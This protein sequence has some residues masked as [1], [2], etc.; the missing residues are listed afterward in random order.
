METAKQEVHLRVVDEYRQ[1]DSHV[2]L[3]NIQFEV[4]RDKRDGAFYNIHKGS[5][6]LTLPKVSTLSLYQQVNWLSVIFP[7]PNFDLPIMKHTS[8]ESSQN[9]FRKS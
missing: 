7:T 6:P 9:K 3:G 4:M 8:H 1:K 2:Y 5:L